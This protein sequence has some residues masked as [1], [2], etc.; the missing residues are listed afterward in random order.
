MPIPGGTSD[1]LGNRYETLWAT[2]QLLR[3]VE[4]AAQSLVLEPID[5]D[6]S[7][8][9]EFYITES[10]GSV[11]Y[12]SVKR[13]TTRAAG[14]TIPLL[15]T[16]DSRGRSIVKDLLAHVERNPSH[17]AVFASTL[18][19][20]NFKELQTYATDSTSFKARLERSVELKQEFNDYLLPICDNDL[21]RARKFLLQTRVFTSDEDQL[22]ERLHFAIRQLLFDERGSSIDVDAVRGYLGDLLLEFIHRP[23]DRETILSK[24]AT[25]A[26]RRR[27]WAIEKTVTDQIDVLCDSYVNPLRSEFINGAFIQLG[28][29]NSIIGADGRPVGSKILVVGGAGGGKSSVLATT[30]ERLR[31]S[32]VPVIPISFDGPLDGLATTRGLGQKLN[33][34]ESPAIVLA[35]LSKGGPGVL[36]IDQLDAVSVAAGRRTELWPLFDILRRE[37]E[38]YPNLSLVVGCRSFDLEHDH[39]MR[40]LKAEGT[41]IVEIKSLTEA[42]IDACLK[43]A[44][45]D[46]QTVNLSLKPVIAV[47][48]HLSMYLNLPT[49]DQ[50]KV[51]DRDELFDRFWTDKERKTSV[52]LGHTARWID[53][54]DRLTDWL[55]KN[56]QLSAPA[57]VLDGLTDDASA[58]TSE[59]VLLLVDSRYRFFHETFFDYAFAR[60]FV[61]HDFSLPNLLRSGEQHLF[62]R[63]QVRQVLAYLRAQDRPRYLC[64]LEAV[65]TAEDIRFHIKNLIFQ[66]ISSLTD[67]QKEEWTILRKSASNTQVWRHV[68]AIAVGRPKWFDLLDSIGFFDD[69]L[70]SGDAAREQ[71]AIWLIGWHQTLETR[72]GRVAELLL[73][74]RKEGDQWNNYLRYVC[75]SGEVFGSRA[76]FDLFLSLIDTGV[77]DGFRPG[78]AVNDTW[79]EVLYTMA[80]KHPELACEAIAH[81]LKRSVTTWRETGGDERLWQHIDRG[82]GGDHVIRDAAKAPL[83]YTKQILPLVAEIVVELVVEFGDR[84]MRD[85]LWSSRTFGDNTIQIHSTILSTLAISLEQ[86]AKTDPNEL[87]QLLEPYLNRPHD[88]IVYLVLR[89]WTAAPGRYADRLVDYLIS[90]PRRLKVG[91]SS[92]NAGGGSA[93]IYTSSQAVKTASSICTPDRFAALERVI[94]DLTDDWEAKNPPIRGMIQLALLRA[95]DDSRISPAGKSKLRELENKF[96]QIEEKEPLNSHVSIVGPPISA[97]AQVKMSDVQWLKA[98]RKYAGVQHR[99][100]RPTIS[101]G[102]EQ[103]LAHSVQEHSK[104]DPVR[105]IGLADQMADDLPSSYFD[106]ILLGVAN[107]LSPN[108]STKSTPSLDQVVSLVRRVHRLPNKPCGRWVGFLM[109]KLGGRDWPEDVID[110]IAWYAIND[111]D[112]DIELWKTPSGGGQ[113]YYG[114]DIHSAGMNSVRGGIAG[115]IAHLLFDKPDR[116]ERLRNG[117]DHLVHDKTIAVRSCTIEP[118]LAV[119]NIDSSVAISWFGECVAADTALL[120][121][122]DVERFLYF[123]SHRNYIAIRP[124]LQTMLSVTDDKVVESAARQIC[125]AAFSIAE[126][127]EDAATVRTGS[128]IMRKAAAAVY[129]TN[130]ANDTVGPI[131]RETIIQFLTDADDDVRTEAASAFRHIAQITTDEQAKLLKAFVD[132][133]PNRGALE[134]V[135][136]ALEDSPVQL[137][138]LVCGLAERCIEVF[139]EDAGDIS[140]AGSMVAMDLSRIVIRLYTQTEDG[141]IKSRCL[142]L[143]DQM[144]L[145]NFIG[146]SDELQR[147]D[148]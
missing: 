92:W 95:L 132:G 135:V 113:P 72:S 33:L 11:F 117:L 69:A 42:Q 127:K 110:A 120:G 67:P 128:S 54:I 148:R 131:C 123:A 89:A 48:L 68:R 35:G 141:S 50:V 138:D 52:R 133:N 143:I 73:K 111:P 90:D 83:A 30:V 12:W 99:H 7:R 98:M 36:V 38:R 28:D 79:W 100:D 94:I 43:V 93:S 107:C 81:W 114:G 13:Q 87:D 46:P 85:P 39:R 82:G 37:V 8:G 49:S 102:G 34:P 23:I 1:K 26:I 105:F 80:Q 31:K 96:P 74:Y 9:I 3:I 125:L 77:L 21:E 29:P 76:M 101:S 137:P 58:M 60:R 2:D 25:H 121:T 86:L 45:I 97:E 44:K 66:W 61:A 17:L 147:L 103:Q 71:E 19:A 75:R 88:T 20:G 4:G 32:A 106:A 118:L 15:V 136:R 130:V 40:K 129:A 22:R 119:L 122:R 16:Q 115:A 134:E 70:A 91:Y 139:R 18:G 145:Y 65:L 144:E 55:S 146:L 53:V 140:K 47:P 116:F 56:Q 109:E 10:S 57:Y 59:H 124:V 14:W 142:N 78:F 84:L 41:V 108:V 126:S 104:N 24:L 51:H 5:T 64:E 112:P 62:R 6:E 27:D 63:A